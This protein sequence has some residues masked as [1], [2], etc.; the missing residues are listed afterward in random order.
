M[1]GRYRWG[2]T[3][4]CP[5]VWRFC[6]IM[7]MIVIVAAIA[8]GS[9]VTYEALYCF[10]L[11]DKTIVTCVMCIATR[12]RERERESSVNSSFYVLF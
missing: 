7:E 2:Y 6:H 4:A 3:R 9:F 11:G 12:K 1:N 10:S 5:C 8:A